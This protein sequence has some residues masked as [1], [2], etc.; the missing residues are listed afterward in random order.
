MKVFRILSVLVAFAVA[1]VLRADV[2]PEK[3]S[4]LTITSPLEVPGA[5]L[6]PG[7]Y[8]VK[9][10]DTE[11]NRNVVTFTTADETKVIAMAIATPHVAADDP[12]HSTFVF[13]AVPEGA[14]KVLRTWFAPNDRYGQDFVYP[15]ERAA[16]LR[17]TTNSEVPVM[18]AEQSREISDRMKSPPPAVAEAR[19]PAPEPPPPAAVSDSDKTPATMTA[20]ATTALPKTASKTPLLLVA[21]LVALGIA[22]GLRFAGRA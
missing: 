16:A 15:A 9:L 1:G 6:E 7:T 12:Q 13:Y 10:A 22:S 19:P 18:T 5:V 2:A 11:S 17:Q 4:T 20:D 14:T 3:K 21:G 8:V